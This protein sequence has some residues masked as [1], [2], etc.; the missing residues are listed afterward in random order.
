MAE[1][2]QPE[3]V[4][5]KEAYQVSLLSGEEGRKIWSMTGRVRL[6]M[7]AVTPSLQYQP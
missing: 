2:L 7:G 5:A 6:M 1:K 4:E 3:G